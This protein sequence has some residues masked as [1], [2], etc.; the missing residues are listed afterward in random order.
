MVRARFGG[1]GAVTVP[2]LHPLL[3]HIC[4][5]RPEVWVDRAATGVSHISP[6]QLHS[7][8]QSQALMSMKQ[9]K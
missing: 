1:G 5:N 6:A 4:A 2:C 3:A 8:L 9:M 7:L